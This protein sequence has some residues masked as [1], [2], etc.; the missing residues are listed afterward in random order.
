[1]DKER[2]KGTDF[3]TDLIWKVFFPY[4]NRVN[5]QGFYFFCNFDPITLKVI[6]KGALENP[7]GE[8]IQFLMK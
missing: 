6:L 7:A 2:Y 4:Y 8:K 3:V 1:M 5:I